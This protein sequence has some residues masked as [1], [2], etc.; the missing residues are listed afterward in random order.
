MKVY[1]YRRDEKI[2]SAEYAADA[3]SRFAGREKESFAFER[4]EHGKPYVTGEEIYFSLS[5]SG[6]ML[7][8]AVAENEVGADIE[9]MRHV[10]MHEKNAERCFSG[11]NPKRE[12]VFFDLWVRKEAFLKYTGEGFS[13][14]I[15]KNAGD[16]V[17][18][19]SFEE[20]EGYMTAV[21]A[22]EEEDVEVV[23][24]DCITADQVF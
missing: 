8:C 22:G 19:L 12:R 13:G 4:G 3:L 11:E 2:T 20:P 5:H 6:E 23:R 24:V 7:I 17:F 1:I 18:M 16:D 14:G 10:K 15:D 9:K 21:C